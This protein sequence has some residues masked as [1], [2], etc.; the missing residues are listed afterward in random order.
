MDWSRLQLGIKNS[1]AYCLGLRGLHPDAV[2]TTGDIVDLDLLPSSILRVV[3][4]SIC[5]RNPRDVTLAPV[6]DACQDEEQIR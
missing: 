4:V 6:G 3:P 1:Q 5:S 2:A